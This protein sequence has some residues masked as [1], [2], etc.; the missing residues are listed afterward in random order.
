MG[1]SDD[2]Y[3]A[4]TLDEIRSMFTAAGVTYPP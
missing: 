4:V 1:N 2:I 3:V